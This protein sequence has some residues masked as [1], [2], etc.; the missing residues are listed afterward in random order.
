MTDNDLRQEFN[1][2][3]AKAI[4]PLV[5][6]IEEL[7]RAVILLLEERNRKTK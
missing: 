1:E 4:A 6:R 2:K 5:K 7:E 3:I